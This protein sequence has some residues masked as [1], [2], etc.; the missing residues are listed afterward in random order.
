M[1]EL[2]LGTRG[3]GGTKLENGFLRANLALSTLNVDLR[4]R[5]FR[6]ISRGAHLRVTLLHTRERSFTG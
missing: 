6:R 1:I 2:G 4:S 3:N 5:K